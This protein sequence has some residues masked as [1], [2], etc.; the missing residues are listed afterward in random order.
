MGEILQSYL[1]NLS[2]KGAGVIDHLNE[3][4]S[5][6][7][8]A[9]LDQL[10]H[11]TIPETVKDMWGVF[12]GTKKNEDITSGE[13]W[14]D[15]TFRYFSV[16]DAIADYAISL[17]L[18][19]KE[20]EFD[21]YLPKG[22]LPIASPGDGSRLLVNCRAGSPSYGGVYELVHG[23]GLIK[24]SISL[25]RYFET[26]DAALRQGGLIVEDSHVIFVD[27][28]FYALAK[29]MNP[30]SDAYNDDLPAAMD[31]KDWLSNDGGTI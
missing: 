29:Q 11:C 28:I 10:P 5:A 31:V 17:E 22:F 19:Q 13:L 12:N 7:I 24:H 2:S 14:L 6:N 30:A 21:E 3:A 9:S 26:I 8:L 16:S 1:Q 25:P 15:G 4:A 23:N 18:W 27:N 20:P